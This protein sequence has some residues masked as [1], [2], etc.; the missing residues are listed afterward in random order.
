MSGHYQV[1][2]RTEL[3]SYD[4]DKAA[5]MALALMH[6]ASWKEK[7]G[8]VRAWKS[9]PWEIT[10]HL[11]EKGYLSDPKGTAKF[12]FLTDDGARLADDPFRNTRNG[13]DIKLD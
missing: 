9:L 12:V 3:L 1:L 2:A 8:G 6:L 5:E 10:D 11:F 4:K 7:N 13:E